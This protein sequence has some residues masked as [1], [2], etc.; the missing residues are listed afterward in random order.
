M[1]L[2]ADS[3]ST[4]T[5]WCLADETQTIAFKTAGINPFFQTDDEI[6]KI[7]SREVLE[8]LPVTDITEVFFYGAGCATPIQ[9]QMISGLLRYVIGCDQVEVNSDLLGAARALCGHESGIACILGTGSNSCYYNGKNIEQHVSPLGFIL[10]DE[11]SGADLGR[12]LVADCLKE[13]LSQPLRD[14]FLPV[15]NFLGNRFYKLFIKS[16]FRTGFSLRFLRLLRKILTNLK[17][18]Y[19]RSMHSHLFS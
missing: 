14:R 18:G 11:G 3:G 12:R 1:I 5:D 4:K 6:R 7:L 19:W 17:Y 2:I 16:R 15:F 13:E 10:G 9:C 8:R